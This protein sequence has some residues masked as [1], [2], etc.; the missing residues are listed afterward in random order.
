MLAIA[1]G[2]IEEIKDGEFVKR[3]CGSKFSKGVLVRVGYWGCIG[4]VG[5]VIGSVANGVFGGVG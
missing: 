4:G 3:G 5:T 1:L 2:V